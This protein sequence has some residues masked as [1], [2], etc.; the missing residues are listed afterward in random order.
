MELDDL[1]RRITLLEDVE[2]IKHLKARYALLCDTG[3]DPDAL[4]SLFTDDGVWDG[5]DIWGRYEGTEAL[6]TFFEG[7]STMLPFAMHFM[8]NPIIDVNGD[9]ATG[10]WHLLQACTYAATGDAVWGG[11]RYFETYA[12]LQGHWKFRY[13]RLDSSFWTPFTD[14]WVQ[15][16]FVQESQKDVKR[17]VN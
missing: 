8:V 9:E 15:R 1:R 5:G 7:A 6:W 14:G 13:V 12:K 3:Y 16:P 11:G 17:A 4:T 10:H 2:A